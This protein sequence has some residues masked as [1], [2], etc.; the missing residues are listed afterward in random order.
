MLTEC[1]I[2]SLSIEM[3]VGIIDH[4]FMSLVWISEDEVVVHLDFLFGVCVLVK[5]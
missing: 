4:F 5:F 3:L 1:C 2:F